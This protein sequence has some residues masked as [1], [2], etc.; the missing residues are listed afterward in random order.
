MIQRIAVISTSISPVMVRA[1]YKDGELILEERKVLPAR[2]KK[3]LEALHELDVPKM[4]NAGF[5][6]L[7]DEVNSGIAHDIGAT[8]M[9]LSDRHTDGR[10]VIVVAFQRLGEL[11]R[12]GSII[13]PQK[14]KNLF[15]ISNSLVDIEY[16]PAGEPIY[17]IDWPS[18]KAEHVLI[19]LV[20]YST[21]FNNVTS[22]AYIKDMQT[23]SAEKER[24]HPLKSFLNII[25]SH[26]EQVAK[27]SPKAKLTGTRIDDNT[28][29]L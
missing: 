19:L 25:R 24:P 28:V 8:I 6:V 23:A 2:R 10:P 22:S 3:M 9:S 26:E 1:V 29:I 16:N 11:K 7:V 13:Y 5:K 4:A 17:R 15:E 18:L 14:S 27:D 21:M 20:V 12:Q